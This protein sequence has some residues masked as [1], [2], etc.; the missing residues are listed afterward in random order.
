MRLI[1]NNTFDLSDK[2]QRHCVDVSVEEDE[3][4][5]NEIGGTETALPINWDEI[6]IE[7][8]EY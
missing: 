8:G 3:M 6:E 2:S 1:K 5:N 7:I 4:G